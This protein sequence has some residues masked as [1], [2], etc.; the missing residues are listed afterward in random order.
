M[1]ERIERIESCERVAMADTCRGIAYRDPV[2]VAQERRAGLESSGSAPTAAA[3]VAMCGT[4]IGR[5]QPRHEL[6]TFVPR[7]PC[8][9]CRRNDPRLRFAAAYA[10]VA[11]G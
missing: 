11:N 1:T 7:C 6:G 9:T 3:V 5:R 4:C 10:E 2:V 8:A